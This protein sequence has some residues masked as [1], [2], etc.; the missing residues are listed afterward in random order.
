MATQSYGTENK[1]TQPEKDWNDSTRK[2]HQA[3][4]FMFHSV[5]TCIKVWNDKTHGQPQA[6]IFMSHIIKIC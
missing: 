1:S 6:I 2:Q 5:R 4:I 3:I